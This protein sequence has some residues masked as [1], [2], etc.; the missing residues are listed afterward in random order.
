MVATTAAIVE[1]STGDVGGGPRTRSSTSAFVNMSERVDVS[2]GNNDSS[3]DDDDGAAR[4]F[5][6][7][8]SGKYD[9][10]HDVAHW[11]HFASISLLGF[12]VIEVGG[13]RISL[14][15]HYTE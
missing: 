3:V 10:L 4:Y 8:A 6:D 14:K 12:L 5:K 11:L 1:A 9:A 7:D 2:T 15:V 13:L